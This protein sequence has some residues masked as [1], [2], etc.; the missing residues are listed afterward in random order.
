MLDPQ[1]RN[2]VR[3]TQLDT[4][5]QTRL[6]TVY[7]LTSAQAALAIAR[8]GYIWSND[9]DGCPNFSVHRDPRVQDPALAEVA[10]AFKFQGTVHLQEKL[11]DYSEY[12][13]GSLNLHMSAWPTLYGM[14]GVRVAVARVAAGTVNGLDCVDFKLTPAFIEKCKTDPQAEL[15]LRR[16]RR[17]L[18]LGRNIKVPRNVEERQQVEARTS[19]AE[20]Q[21]TLAKS[22]WNKLRG[23][24]A[25][26]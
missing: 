11:V 3:F 8:S 12:Q 2:R 21:P 19:E 20:P 17:Q 25:D 15:L 24:A 10:L 13:D 14:D 4:E 9:P 5:T 23:K 1:A 18:A 7:H 22:L 16:L 6:R 26:A